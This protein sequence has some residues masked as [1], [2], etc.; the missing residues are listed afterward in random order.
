MTCFVM[1]LTPVSLPCLSISLFQFCST[2]YSL[3]YSG[4]SLTYIRT[5]QWA[6]WCNPTSYL[7]SPVPLSLFSLSH[8]LSHR[9]S[10]FCSH[11]LETQLADGVL[12]SIR[13]VKEQERWQ[14]ISCGVQ[15]LF[16]L[17]LCLPFVG[18]LGG[19]R[20]QE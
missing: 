12:F 10:F 15:Q 7:Y 8:S 4:I 14:S 1:I 18:G 2:V 20:A 3:R 9:D 6:S 13:L 16:S 19:T 17:P 11:F 5:I